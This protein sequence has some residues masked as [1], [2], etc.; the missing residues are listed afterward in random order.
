MPGTL[1]IAV[2]NPLRGD[3][4]VAWH[5]AAALDERPL[6]PHTTIHTVHQLLPEL[7][8]EAAQV[9]QVIFVDASL[10]HLPGE[11]AVSALPAGA[12]TATT[13][14]HDLDPAGLLA[15]A[16]RLYGA[17]PSATLVL[18]GGAAFEHTDRLSN[19]VALAVPTAVSRVLA[20]LEATPPPVAP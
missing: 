13:G 9:A 20:L 3:D 10:S 4:G 5:V 12:A 19:Q 1:I 17:V 8:A 7:A 15:L 18:I 14:T 11:V 16:G 6:P 2:G